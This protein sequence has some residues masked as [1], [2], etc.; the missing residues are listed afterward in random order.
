MKKHSTSIKTL[1]ILL[2]VALVAAGCQPALAEEVTVQPDDPFVAIGG[3]TSAELASETGPTQTAMLYTV[4]TAPAEGLGASTPASAYPLTVQSASGA[5]TRLGVDLAEAD[6][7]TEG[8][9]WYAKAGMVV[10]CVALIGLTTWAIVE[11][12]H[13]GSHDHDSSTHYT[14]YGD[15]GST[16]NIRIGADNN[17]T[18]TTSGW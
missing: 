3:P 17:S 1:S 18:S 8:W 16:M 13:Q 11:A 5:D 14:I 2:V 6:K 7:A 4:P 12:S 9:P 10:G 15:D